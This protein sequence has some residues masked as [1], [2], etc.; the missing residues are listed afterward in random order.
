[1]SKIIGVFFIFLAMDCATSPTGRSQL[2]ALPDGQLNSMG[3]QSFQEMKSKQT[4]ETDPKIN[5]YVKCV[6]APLVAIGGPLA[7]IP[8]WEVV[9]FRDNS[10]NAF[11]LPG[12]KIGVH[13]GILKAARNQDQLAA[14]IGHEVGHVIARHGNE[15]MSQ[16]L[17]AQTVLLT[18]NIMTQDSKSRGMI[19]GLL[20]AGATVGVLLP[21]SRAQESE[22]D[23]IGLDLMSQAGFDPR[24][25]VRLWE[26]MASGGGQKPPEILSTHP[27]DETRMENLS[28]NIPKSM[29][30]YQSA[31]K[32]GRQPHCSL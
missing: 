5:A 20:G 12:G 19:M 11:A 27:S 4:I 26:N 8:N 18:A 13:T 22:A 15:R 10:A 23:V 14:V 1:M 16:A 17:A 3:V 2:I 9:V 7:G 32:Q 21:F 30:T 28:E 29:G 31:Q 6:A 24:E 25:S